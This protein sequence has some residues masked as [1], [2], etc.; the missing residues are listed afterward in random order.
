MP[1]SFPK[2]LKETFFALHYIFPELLSQSWSYCLSLY[3]CQ[4]PFLFQWHC[5]NPLYHH[6]SGKQAQQNL[7]ISL[8]HQ[9]ENLLH[10]SA[11]PQIL[12]KRKSMGQFWK[13]PSKHILPRLPS[14]L[15]KSVS[16]ESAPHLFCNTHH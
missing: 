4:F 12:L 6:I 11:L 14:L 3:P 10:H 16:Q 2:R 5:L 8:K 1:C 9:S 7:H 15:P 13:K